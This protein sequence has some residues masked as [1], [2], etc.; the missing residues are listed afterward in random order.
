M[1]PL[2]R[3][4]SERSTRPPSSGNAGSRLNTRISPL[5]SAWYSTITRTTAGVELGSSS[6][7]AP[8]QTAITAVTAG[9]ARA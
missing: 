4:S 7:I 1:S 2:C 3:H 6:A 5:T 8:K 9:P